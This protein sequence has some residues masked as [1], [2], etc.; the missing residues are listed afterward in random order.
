MSKIWVIKT[1]LLAILALLVI[2]LGFGTAGAEQDELWEAKYFNNT[3]FGGGP[4]VKRQESEINYNWGE[5]SPAPGINDDYFSVEW[6]RKIYLPAGTYRFTATMDDGMQVWV[7]GQKIINSWYD[8]QVHSVSADIQLPDGDHDVHVKYYEAGGGAIARLT[9]I[10]LPRPVPEVISH[11][12]GEYFN[13]MFLYPPASTVRDDPEINFDWGY[14]SPIPGTIQENHVSIRWTRSVQFSPGRYRFSVTTD[15]GVRLWVNNV[16]LIDQ[17][18][19]QGAT[20]YEA[21]I[22]LPGG[23][24]PVKMEYYENRDLASARLSWSPTG[25]IQPPP[26]PDTGGGQT[27]MVIAYWLNVRWGPGV[28]YGIITTISRGTV[29]GLTHRNPAGTWARIILPSGATGWVNASYLQSTIP[30]STLPVLTG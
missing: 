12:R 9:W 25:G 24:I 23:L 7:A 26:P 19:D 14:N 2:T 28:G 21:D 20:T 13:N 10:G 30:V 17:W 1:G 3:G 6:K 18:Q 4:V 5:G 29:V 27:A 15:D 8:S 22:Q 11:W 16:L